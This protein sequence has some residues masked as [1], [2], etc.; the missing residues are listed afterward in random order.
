MA[1]LAAN[2]ATEERLYGLAE[3]YHRRAVE[4][5]RHLP[6][7]S[8]HRL[9]YRLHNY[10]GFLL[11]AGRADEASRVLV[12]MESLA[13]GLYEDPRVNL[14][15]VA[16][17]SLAAF[18]NG[19]RSIDTLRALVDA[20]MAYET[21]RANA[22][23]GA[24]LE[25][26]FAK[27]RP[28]FEEAAE[29]AL[30]LGRPAYALSLLELAKSRSLVESVRQAVSSIPE[31][32][33]V[34]SGPVMQGDRLGISLFVMESAVMAIVADG[35]DNSVKAYDVGGDGDRQADPLG[36]LVTRLVDTADAERGVMS[37]EPLDAVL[38]HPTFAGLASRLNEL[39]L[40]GREVWLSP[41]RF[42][43]Q[44]PLQLA[45]AVGGSAD[46]LR[47]TLTPTLALVGSLTSLPSRTITSVAAFGDPLGD[48]PF[49]RAEAR[50]VAGDGARTATAA[51][52]MPRRSHECAA[53]VSACCTWRVMGASTECIPSV[54][55]SCWP[56]VMPRLCRVLKPPPC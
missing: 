7:D 44:T 50:L 12:E 34:G 42:L 14:A 40:E 29:V 53:K 19:D 36:R 3:E 26:L 16:V 52:A 46:E 17:K 41:H 21:F 37:A 43:H 23:G 45:N 25:G 27:M 6:G 28:P 47:W 5:G 10:H 11:E 18:R 20:C 9:I 13:T 30:S 33:S 39:A 51:H 22:R 56:A 49:A 2:V 24:A 35:R 31:L 32:G 8:R 4:T 15:M 54:A 48:L 1:A 38:R 55:A